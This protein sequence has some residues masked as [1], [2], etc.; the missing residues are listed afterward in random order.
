MFTSPS[1]EAHSRGPRAGTFGR[2]TVAQYPAMQGYGCSRQSQHSSEDFTFCLDQ[3]C[4]TVFTTVAEGAGR[5]C[6]RCGSVCRWTQ[7]PDTKGGPG[8]AASLQPSGSRATLRS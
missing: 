1:S 4:Q 8:C 6:A 2:G 5:S 3:I 7:L